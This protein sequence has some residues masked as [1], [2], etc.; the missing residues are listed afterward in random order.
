MKNIVVYDPAMCCSTGVCGPS[1]NSELARFAG[2]LER[3]AKQGV[4][5]S[6]YNL[7]Q[8]P[9]AFAQGEIKALLSSKGLLGLPAIFVDGKALLVG[10]YP[11]TEEI[12][13]WMAGNAEVIE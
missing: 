8:Q 13:A 9:Q 6:R 11:S 2:D 3:L 4:E 10:R 7:S 5:V 12:E 1:P